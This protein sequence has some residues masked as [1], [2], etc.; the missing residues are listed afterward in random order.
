MTLDL[1][2]FVFMAIMSSIGIVGNIHVLVVYKLSPEMK[3]IAVRIFILWLAATDLTVCML[4]VPFEMFD[5]RYDYIFAAPPV[6]CKFFRYVGHATYL[7]S[8]SFLTAIAIERGLLTWKNNIGYTKKSTKWYNMV[9][10]IIVVVMFVLTTP[11][12]VFVGVEKIKI[13]QHTNM[14]GNDCTV[15]TEYKSWYT[16]FNIIGMLIM[17]I[18]FL[19]VI[20]IYSKILCSICA[21][22]EKDKRRKSMHHLTAASDSNQW[23]STYDRGRRLTISLMIATAISYV[24]FLLFLTAAYI[25]VS[26]PDLFTTFIGP[27]TTILYRAAFINNAVNPV[28]YFLADDRFRSECFTLYQRCSK[29]KIKQLTKELSTEGTV[30]TK[31][32]L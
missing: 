26:N 11:A 2:A 28:V 4:C 6:I 19:S 21:Q 23:R 14:T 12:L 8:C 30:E 25:Q 27:V 5:S 13:P 15:L 29:R 7:T 31:F 32:S 24:G 9:S 16:T 17:S 22:T 3:R 10:C 1:P 20:A 18:F